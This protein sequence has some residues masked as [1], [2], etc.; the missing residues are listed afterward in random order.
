MGE[1]LPLA[2]GE[3]VQDTDLLPPPQEFIYD[4]GADETGSSGN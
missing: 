2:G 4:M 1:V 3:V